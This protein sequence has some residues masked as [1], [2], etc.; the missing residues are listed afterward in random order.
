MKQLYR[1]RT[2]RMLAGV[3]G[4]LGEYYDTDPN[5]LRIIFVVFLLL[6]LLVWAFLPIG[7]LGYFFAWMLLPENS[8]PER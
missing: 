4:G 6:S 3:F 5:L 1:S 7:V 2:K 8:G